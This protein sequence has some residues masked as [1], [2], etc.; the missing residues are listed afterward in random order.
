MLSTISKCRDVRQTISESEYIKCQTHTYT[1]THRHSVRQTEEQKWT[2]EH[3]QGLGDE[4][5]QTEESQRRRYKKRDLRRNRAVV[6]GAWLSPVLDKGTSP[7][8]G[9]AVEQRT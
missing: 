2:R 4:G 9:T 8:G 1:V 5:P 7:H 3:T 6:V